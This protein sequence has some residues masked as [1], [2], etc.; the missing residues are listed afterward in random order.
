MPFRYSPGKC[1]TGGCGCG[2]CTGTV[3]VALNSRCHAGDGS[4]VSIAVRDHATGIEVGSATTDVNGHAC[5]SGIRPGSYDV[6]PSK[7]DCFISQWTNQTVGC[8]TLNLAADVVCLPYGAR[9]FGVSGCFGTPL[10]DAIITVTGP[11]PGS[12]QTGA[13]GIAYYHYSQ[14][15][16]YT[17]VV[18]HPSGRFADSDPV[19]WTVTNVCDSSEAAG[20]QLAPAAGYQCCTIQRTA[21]PPSPYPIKTTLKITDPGGAISFTSGDCSGT[22]CAGGRVMS[23]VQT[24]AGGI[25]S[26]NGFT[27]NLPPTVGTGSCFVKYDVVLSDTG[28]TASQTNPVAACSGVQGCQYL[29]GTAPGCETKYLAVRSPGGSCA[30]FP[31]PMT[32]GSTGFTINSLNPLNVTF[33]FDPGGDFG[34]SVS[35][36]TKIPPYATSIVVSE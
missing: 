4:G 8:S 13:D 33:T 16:T 14:V 17:A 1:N 23:N 26:C 29:Y 28:C 36:L 6:I 19:S 21:T 24:A 30:A 11:S 12:V 10:P 7:T 3:C 20:V 18:S 22:A 31:N 27:F 32:W 9:K 15:G 34:P 35:P 5:V 2:E 25:A